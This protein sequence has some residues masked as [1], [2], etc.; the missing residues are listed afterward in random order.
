MHEQT[1]RIDPDTEATLYERSFLAWGPKYFRTA[2]WETKTAMAPA[3]KK[4]GI[5]QVRTW[6]ERY[7][8]R[9]LTP[10]RRTSMKVSIRLDL[11]P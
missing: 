9:P 11:L 2:A 4:A 8:A 3:M 10:P 1:A 6:A 5:R 7:S